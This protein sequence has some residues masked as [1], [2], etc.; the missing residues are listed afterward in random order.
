MEEEKECLRGKDLPL[1][2]LWGF[3]LPKLRVAAIS[4]DVC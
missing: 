3:V 2:E 4:V 1:D